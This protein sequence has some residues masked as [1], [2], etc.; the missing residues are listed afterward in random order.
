M[1]ETTFGELT[2]EDFSARLAS[3][4]PV[5]GGGSASAVAGSLAGALL[6]M[7]AGLSIGR[8][9][10]AAYTA[11]IERA[12]AAGERA[13]SRLLD[14]ADEDATVYTVFGAAMKLPRETDEQVAARKQA[15]SAAAL[16]AC[17]VPM[18]VVWEMR[19]LVDEVES[20][21]GRSN[22]NAASDLEV[23]ALL[24]DAA[25]QG[26]GANVLIN[27]PMVG[28]ERAVGAM[29]ARLDGE[30]RAIT[31]AVARIRR[32]VGARELREPETE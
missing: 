9:K 6:A 25:A 28:D 18:A 30:Q 7:V 16:A 29:T 32:L 10:Y 5:P 22:L 14:L 8:P 12:K 3:A 15:I 27:L 17:E 19:T 13:R 21:A 2:L 23:A 4:E 11:T 20:L 24:A 26:A 1:A 31:D